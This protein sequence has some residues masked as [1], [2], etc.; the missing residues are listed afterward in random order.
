M[1]YCSKFYRILLNIS[2]FNPTAMKK[3]VPGKATYRLSKIQRLFASSLFLQLL[4]SHSLLPKAQPRD[5][6]KQP[7]QNPR[8][9]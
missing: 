5:Q 8:R 1:L 7:R 3:T 6:A 2:Q 9:Y 4:R